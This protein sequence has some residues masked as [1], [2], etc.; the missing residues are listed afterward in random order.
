MP[1]V[2]TQPLMDS[3]RWKMLEEPQRKQA[4]ELWQDAG[5][6]EAERAR[7]LEMMQQPRVAAPAEVPAAAVSPATPS[8]WEALTG[9]VTGTQRLPFQ[10]GAA[11][12]GMAPEDLALQASRE[13][14]AGAVV[15]AVTGMGTDPR[16]VGE[17]LGSA[18]PVG[19]WR[20]VT[21][22]LGAGVGEGVR[23]WWEG[24][25]FAPGK[26][27]QEMA[28]SALP[29]IFESAGR[30]ALKTAARGT[31]TGKTMLRE[32]AAQQARQAPARIFQP[33][34]ADEISLAFTQVR[35]TQLPIDPSA[36]STHV[37]SMSPGRQAD[38]RH[39][40][41]ILDREHATGGR[42]V[43]L[44]DDLQQGRAGAQDIGALQDMRSALRQR[45]ER[46]EKAPDRQQFVRDMQHVVDY[47]IDHG[48][49]Q[50]ARG[51][52]APA[53]REMLHQAR[54]DWARRM[55][56]DDMSGMVEQHIRSGPDL[57]SV[58]LNLAGFYDDIR[59]ERSSISQSVNRALDL[60][61][62]GRE[63]FEASMR[64]VARNFQYVT[65]PKIP[66]LEQ[67]LSYMALSPHLR[68]GLR[69]AIVQGRGTVS[70]NVLATLVNAA[71]REQGVG[72]EPAATR[73]GV[74]SQYGPG[75]MARQTD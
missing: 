15:G 33:K 69:Q 57:Q 75:G 23:Q 58:S 74:E 31:T 20:S 67:A 32:E 59:K 21:G 41:T 64:D 3:P 34:P 17:L 43:Q 71:L 66:G 36:M 62:G 52:Q 48:L 63:R 2:D 72:R 27:G 38:L 4:L 61:P 26:I 29:Q 47:T 40:L 11:P 8:P 39:E 9:A 19:P 54:S 5:T 7:M 18:L 37:Q 10:S 14:P 28:Y 50:G 46:L 13:S 12:E 42:Y 55:A 16:N 60:T 73:E 68:E 53:T 30:A 35:Q 56:A 45:A 24:E 49:V 44:Y 51:A 25:P 22:A 1:F 70:P 6:S 65:L